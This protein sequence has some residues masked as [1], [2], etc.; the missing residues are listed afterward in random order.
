MKRTTPPKDPKVNVLLF[1]PPKTGKTIAAASSPGPVLLLNADTGN[2]TRQAHLRTGGSLFEVAQPDYQEGELQWL[3]LIAE[4]SREV[5][6]EDCEF[7]TVIVDPISD[8]YRQM[9]EEGSRRAMRPSLPQY[10]DVGTH[11]ERF[12]RYLCKRPN[13]NVVIVCHDL[14]VKDE[15]SGDMIAIPF[16]G[17]QAGSAVLGKK[18]QAMVDVVGYT[19]TVENEEGETHYVA[20]LIPAKGRVG[21]D[22][23]AC[24]GKVRD[25]NLTEWIEAI[26]AKEQAESQTPN[27]DDAPAPEPIRAAA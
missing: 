18:L 24:L 12:C 23:F 10:G 2:A 27:S 21:G 13:I 6:K 26:K 1:G 14:T 25:M 20:Q 17:T 5:A 9:L 8:L 4:V 19:G 22:R 11:I 16:T 3:R 15:G 7:E